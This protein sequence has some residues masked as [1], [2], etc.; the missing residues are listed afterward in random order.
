MSMPK[1]LS[2][3]PRALI[4]GASRGI[5]AA[6][7]KK[8]AAD[9]YPVIVHYQSRD[10]AAQKVKGEI[11]SAGGTVELVRFDVTDYDAAQAA[12][13]GLLS[14]P[15]PI[16][17]LVNNAG[18]TADAPFP[19]MD[20]EM[21]RKVI[22]TSLDGFYNVT[23]PL[24]MPMIKLRWGRIVNLTSVSGVIGNRG[25]VNY[26]AAKAGLIGATKALAQEM[27]KRN[28]TVNAVAPGPVETDMFQGAIDNGTP[29][30]EVLKHIPMRR[31]ATVDDVAA[32]VS[33]LCSDAAG[34]ITGQ[35]VGVNGGMC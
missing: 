21:W 30:E 9:G 19:A 29:L 33:F 15:R 23:Q 18:V 27:A 7:A 13:T 35:V 6:I 1:T 5:G 24:S 22:A 8:L 12:I 28:V 26:S 4:T 14:D 20:R 17:V 16:G 25:Q 32:I 2:E 34:Y 10:D 3:K 11:E 31:I